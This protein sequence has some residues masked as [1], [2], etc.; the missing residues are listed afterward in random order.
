MTKMIYLTISGLTLNGAELSKT[1]FKDGLTLG[2]NTYNLRPAAVNPSLEI[3]KNAERSLNGTMNVDVIAK[4]QTIEV[5]FPVIDDDTFDLL[6]ELFNSADA[7]L[8]TYTIECYK[9]PPQGGPQGEQQQSGGE[10]QGGGSQSNEKKWYIDGISYI[11]FA[12]GDE[13][14]WQNFTVKFE[15]I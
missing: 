3:I 8:K 7:A 10:Q 15:E 9:K 13:M 4:K 2:G 14:R 6:I 11:P 1:E 12:V 5:V